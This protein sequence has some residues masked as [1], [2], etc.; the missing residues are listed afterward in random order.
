M[1]KRVIVLGKTGMLGSMVWQWLNKQSSFT[2][3]G[4]TRSKKKLQANEKYFELGKFVDHP[5]QLSFLKRADYIINCIGITKPHCHDDNPV[6][7]K[8]AILVNSW[9]PFVLA[10]Y[11]KGTKV[12]VIQIATDCVYSGAKG[13][14][15]ESD[16]HDALDVYGKTKSLGEV[17]SAN[18]LHI[19]S[20]II[21]PEVNR[22]KFLLEW[23][24]DQSE[25][26]QVN[27]FANHDWNGVTTLQF[28]QLCGL[29]ITGRKFNGLRKMSHI[30]HF[31]PNKTVNKYQ[32]LQAANKVYQKKV[33]IKK[34]NSAGA[35]VDR[36]LATQ[37]KSLSKIFGS[38]SIEQALQDLKECL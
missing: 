17:M 1:N 30:H 25:G 26:S 34:I 23:F 19:R 12:K 3:V 9:F 2:V 7:V 27:G 6:E 8:N 32:L 28:A 38:S 16:P 22:K 20:S 33:K 24:L 37:Y 11:L 10:D 14:Y 31:V 13:Q 18:F 29:I 35:A 15:Q 5:T 36:T 21:G 4:T